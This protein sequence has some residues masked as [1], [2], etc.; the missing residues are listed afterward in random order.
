MGVKSVRPE[1]RIFILLFIISCI[2]AAPLLSQEPDR[3]LEIST[4]TRVVGSTES[5]LPLWLEAN[6][7]GTVQPDQSFQSSLGLSLTYRQGLSD[8]FGVFAAV[9]GQG[10][11]SEDSQLLPRFGYAGVRSGP[12][13]LHGGWHPMR[14]GVLPA[15]ALS[16]GSMAVSGN[17]RPIPRITLR[18]DGFLPLDF[19]SPLLDTKFGI[20]HGWMDEDRYVSNPLY[21]EKWLYLRA[22]EPERFSFHLGLV[23]MAMWAGDSP[24]DKTIDPTFRNFVRIFLAQSGG[25]EASRSD[26]INRAGDHFG[27]WDLGLYLAF[28][29]VDFNAYH[30]HF[31]EDR[32]GGYWLRNGSDGLTGL[33]FE[34]TGVEWVWP[35]TFL[36]ER[37]NTTYQTGPYHDLK[38]LGED[39][40]LGGRDSYYMNGAYPSGWTYHGRIVGTPLFLTAGE[41]EDLRIGSNR[42]EVNHF[43]TGGSV[44]ENIS[45]RYMFSMIGHRPAYSFTSLFDGSHWRYH[46][47]LEVVTDGLFGI[48]PLSATFGTGLS[49]GEADN[50]DPSLGFV[51]QVRWRLY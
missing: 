21:H 10:T 36:Y 12:F 9:S 47:Y 5:N 37:V 34:L 28:S 44:N 40:T 8:Y 31:F 26:Q 41:G 24:A 33:S 46:H 29:N 11:L 35:D 19:I 51:L 45:Y 43:G 48:A 27:I 13:L 32:R 6:R 20:S 42:V 17:A 3:N 39:V 1:L 2:S 4:D 25:D 38:H 22:G 30:H 15:P 7:G 14:L 16:T 50:L 23:H 49:N 18:T